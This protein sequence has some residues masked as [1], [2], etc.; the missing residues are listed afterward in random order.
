MLVGITRDRDWHYLLSV[1]SDLAQ[2][3]RLEKSDC[4][5]KNVSEGI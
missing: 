5:N 2:K 1:R 4:M 3:E